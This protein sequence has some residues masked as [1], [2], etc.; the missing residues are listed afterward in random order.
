MSAI[1]D[2]ESAFKGAFGG[3][4]LE[5]RCVFVGGLRVAIVCCV[6]EFEDMG[7]LPVPELRLAAL[8]DLSAWSKAP[9]YLGRIHPK[10]KGD[11]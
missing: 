5:E 4:E 2:V 9:L 6:W 8:C 11:I 1:V 3:P 10:G 7:E